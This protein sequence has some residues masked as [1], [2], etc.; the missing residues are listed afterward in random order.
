MNNINLKLFDRSDESDFKNKSNCESFNWS[1]PKAKVILNV[2]ETYPKY[3][4]WFVQTNETYIEVTETDSAG[5]MFIQK[6]A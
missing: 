3:K 1:Q 5:T 2:H 4:G 6:A